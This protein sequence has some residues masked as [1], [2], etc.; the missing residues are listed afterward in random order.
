MLVQEVAQNV[1]CGTPPVLSLL[2]GLAG[3]WPMSNKEPTSKILVPDFDEK[4]AWISDDNLEVRFV[5]VK[6]FAICCMTNGLAEI[7]PKLHSAG[8]SVMPPTDSDH[9]AGH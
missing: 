7:D 3:V 2:G 4:S 9:I 1:H 5:K 8:F 6:L